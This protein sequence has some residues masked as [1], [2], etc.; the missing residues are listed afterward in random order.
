MTAQPL[1][2]VFQPERRLLTITMRGIWDMAQIETFK[3]SVATAVAEIKRSSAENLFDVL[4]DLREHPLQP[5]DV[6]EA[7]EMVVAGL[8]R[9]PRRAAVVTSPSAL[10]RLQATRLG[11]SRDAHV[12]TSLDDANQWLLS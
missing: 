8:E 2:V 5:R 4:V 6:A 10:H 12:F 3:A 11:R 9:G 1:T 7:L